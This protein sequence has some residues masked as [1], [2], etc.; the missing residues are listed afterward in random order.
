MSDGDPFERVREICLA[1]PEATEKTD[2][3]PVFQVRRKSFVMCMDNHHED[4]RLAV[5]CKAPPGAQGLFVGTDP[6]RFFVPPYV[7]PNGWVGV[8]LDREVEW[9][10]LAGIFADGYRMTAPK[11]LL[12]LLDQ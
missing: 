8:R 5:W 6:E 9:D 1:L 7:G 12:A 2:G 4:G 11:R 10:E 3:R